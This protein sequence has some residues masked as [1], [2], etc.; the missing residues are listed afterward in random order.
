MS[1][2]GEHQQKVPINVD[3]RAHWHGF[4]TTWVHLEELLNSHTSP[5]SS[6]NEY[7]D[8]QKQ[9]MFL[10]PHHFGYTTVGDLEEAGNTI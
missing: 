10:V 6:S 1:H 3:H 7:G 9:K 5:L 8:Q 2:S 4:N